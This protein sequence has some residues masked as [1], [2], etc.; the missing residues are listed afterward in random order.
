LNRGRMAVISLVNSESAGS[1]TTPVFGCPVVEPT[2][3]S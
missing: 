2:A 3:L 1:D